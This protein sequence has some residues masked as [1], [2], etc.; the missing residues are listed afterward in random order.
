MDL[1]FRMKSKAF[2]GIKISVLFIL[3]L[4]ENYGFV[5][6]NEVQGFHWNK[7]QCSLHP[8]AIYWNNGDEIKEKSICGISDDLI[9]DV[10]FVYEVTRLMCEKLDQITNKS[11][12]KIFYFSNGC[13]AQ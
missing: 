8:Y 6:Q 5:V 2:I 1:L 13:A 11:V 7:N 10:D 3:L 4:D 9:H 12:N